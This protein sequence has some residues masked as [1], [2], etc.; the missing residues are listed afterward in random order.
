MLFCFILC[1]L[2]FVKTFSNFNARVRISRPCSELQSAAIRMAILFLLIL[3]LLAVLVVH[4]F[5]PQLRLSFSPNSA[6][7]DFF[8]SDRMLLSRT[9]VAVQHTCTVVLQSV[10]FLTSSLILQRSFT[11][12]DSMQN[13]SFFLK[14][15]HTSKVKIRFK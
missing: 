9:H 8:V 3:Q 6:F 1:I 14:A 12:N 4:R 2:A 11:Q 5:L 13:I 10:V 15:I 7:K